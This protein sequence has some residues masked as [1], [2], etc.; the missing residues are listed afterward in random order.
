[1]SNEENDKGDVMEL[2]NDRRD[3]EE[4]VPPSVLD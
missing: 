3:E 2:I 4:D 1:M